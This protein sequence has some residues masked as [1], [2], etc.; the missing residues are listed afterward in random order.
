M[1]TFLRVWPPASAIN[2]RETCLHSP[3]YPCQIPS[4]GAWAHNKG[5]FSKSHSNSAFTNNVFMIQLSSGS[6]FWP[7]WLDDSAGGLQL[8]P[9]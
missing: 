6:P 2:C 7:V 1:R 4:G 8:L 5:V 9:I 3:S